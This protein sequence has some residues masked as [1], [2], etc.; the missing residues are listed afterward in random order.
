MLTNVHFAAILGRMCHT[1][2]G[3]VIQTHLLHMVIS[4]LRSFAAFRVAHILIPFPLSD[5]GLR[6]CNRSKH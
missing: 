2:S 4:L 1:L 6:R 5:S 3:Y